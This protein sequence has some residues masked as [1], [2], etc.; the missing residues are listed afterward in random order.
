[1]KR[2]VNVSFSSPRTLMNQRDSPAGSSESLSKPA[3]KGFSLNEKLSYPSILLSRDL[4]S[5]SVNSR[6][7]SPSGTALCA[8]DQRS[9]L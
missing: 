9:G 4:I 8:I 2:K 3:N 7:T 6:E 1:M 5:V